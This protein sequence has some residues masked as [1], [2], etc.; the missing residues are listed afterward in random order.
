MTRKRI[1]FVNDRRYLKF[2]LAEV[3]NSIGEP[4]I[5]GR[6]VGGTLTNFKKLMLMYHIF[7]KHKLV[8][9]LPR[10]KQ[11]LKRTLEGLSSLRS[12]PTVAFFNSTRR[13]S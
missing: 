8:E 3:A 10:F 6:W 13:S 9:T 1:L 5:A 4:Y 7:L 12:L 11:S 2:S